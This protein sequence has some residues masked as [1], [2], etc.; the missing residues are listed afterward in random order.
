MS[1]KTAI[2]VPGLGGPAGDLAAGWLQRLLV[3]LLDLSL[4]A[5]QAHWHVL[6]ANFL[7]VHEQLDRVVGDA[8]EWADIVAERSVALGHQVDGRAATIAK[9]STLPAFREGFLGYME[10]VSSIADRLETLAGTS[11]RA[12]EELAAADPGSQDVAVQIM[13][14][15]E[16]HLWM[17]RAQSA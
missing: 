17:F 12:A 11:R 16:K 10:V 1:Q 5:K 6:G 3:E 15:L 7:S 13:L 14:G 4:Q 9:T 8:R 2:G